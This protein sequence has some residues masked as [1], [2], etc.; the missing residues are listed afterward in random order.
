M[1][2]NLLAIWS[3]IYICSLDREIADFKNYIT[4]T[5][6]ERTCRERL[7]RMVDKAV[8]KMSQGIYETEI[9]GSM[10]FGY[11]LGSSD[12][13]VRIYLPSARELVSAPSIKSTTRL[14]WFLFSLIKPMKTLG[15]IDPQLV[16]SR[17]PLLDTRHPESQVSVQVVSANSS[18][19]SMEYLK[20]QIKEDP[21]IL[22]IYAVVRLMLQLR[23]LHDVFHGGLGSYSLIMMI[24]ASTKLLSGASVGEKLINFFDFYTTLDTTKQTV[25]LIPPAIHPKYRH[26]VQI[27]K[28][29]QNPTV[30]QTVSPSCCSSHTAVN[31]CS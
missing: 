2:C 13:D 21:D 9:H 4:L 28:I 1:S 7:A 26:A 19:L 20:P 17:I 8:K 31:C 11:S 24:I 29:P 22:S 16:Y 15:F 12:L 5:E 23:N 25:G 18:R 30:E 27:P 6:E 14:K 3:L 10:A